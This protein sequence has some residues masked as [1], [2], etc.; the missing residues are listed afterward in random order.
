[1]KIFIDTADTDVL[2]KWLKTGIIDGVTTN[3]SH[4]AKRGEDPR[5][6]VEEIC[7]LMHGKDVSIEVTEEDPEKVY[8]QAQEISKIAENVVVKV[9]C[10]ADYYSI[11]HKLVQQDIEV[12]VTLV[13]TLIQGVCMCKLGVK[14]ISPFVGRWDD[15]DADG[16]DVLFQLRDMID[17]YGYQTEILGASLRTVR[18]MHQAIEAGVDVVTVPPKVLEKATT[19]VLTDQGIRKFIDDWKKLGVKQFP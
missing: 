9:P 3:P 7:K 12:N 17:Y 16:I 18:N 14:Y 4:L 8:K 10:H 13:F 5:K 11:I 15:I 19:H 1:M 6:A 2:K